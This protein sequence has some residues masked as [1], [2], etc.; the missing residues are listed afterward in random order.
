MSVHVHIHEML[1]QYF[2]TFRMKRELVFYNDVSVPFSP[3]LEETFHFLAN[4]AITRCQTVSFYLTRVSLIR[5]LLFFRGLLK[6]QRLTRY[7]YSRLTY[8]ML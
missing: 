6:V 4:Y 5:N 7:M 3:L 1:E 8:R 2:N